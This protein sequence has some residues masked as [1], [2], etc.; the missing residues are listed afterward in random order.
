MIEDLK[1]ITELDTEFCKRMQ[2]VSKSSIGLAV[3]GGGDS[4]ALLIMASKW[5]NL[6]K[7]DLKVVT[8]DHH[9][10]PN[11]RDEADYV[12][13]TTNSL[14]HS[15]KILDWYYEASSGNLQAAASDGRKKLISTWAKE[16]NIDIILLGHT[17]N[18]Q[19]ETFLMRLA[20]GSGVDGLAGMKTSKNFY[21]VEWFRPL[22]SFHRDDLRHYLRFQSIKWIEDPSND[23]LKYTR[24]RAR[25]VLKELET[26]GI[27]QRVFL[28]TA[29]RMDKAKV[30][31]NDAAKEAGKEFLT[32][33]DWGD[34]E[35]DKKLFQVKRDETYLRLLA[36]IIKFISGNVYRTRFSELNQFVLALT[37]TNFK[38]RTIG[39][40]I[41]RSVD[42]KTLVLRREPSVPGFI[43][44]VPAK[45]FIWDG[46]WALSLAKNSLDDFEKI[47]P[48]GTFGLSQIKKSAP[49]TIPT[50]SLISLPTLF[51]D[52][53]VLAS[54]FLNF[55]KG[56]GSSL[57]YTK[58]DLINSLVTH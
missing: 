36:H 50:E 30:V 48:L 31:L 26:L 5:A 34:I 43:K 7:R 58:L 41:A 54:P 28:E 56:L 38:A 2:E 13:I 14:G 49:S 9:L 1:K 11:S 27:K 21:G 39:G 33:R 12:K 32:L 37:E 19:A 15:H 45:N 46:R 52:E 20:R 22:L 51:R 6:L 18:D 8:V 55:G 29:Q 53:Q 10:R 24:V 3:S 25:R 4:L 35:V 57:V 23:D 16:Q 42:E 47:G 44:K 17:A 40:I